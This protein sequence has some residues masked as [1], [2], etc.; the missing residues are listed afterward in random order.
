M[1]AEVQGSII[2][3]IIPVQEGAVIIHISLP[4]GPILRL[5]ELT[6]RRLSE[7]ILLRIVILRRPDPIHRLKVL[8]PIEEETQEAAAVHPAEGDN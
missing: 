8:L 5:K 4:E 3:H 7:L 6:L 1:E 2:I